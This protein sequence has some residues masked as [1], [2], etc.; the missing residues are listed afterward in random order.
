[1]GAAEPAQ[2]ERSGRGAGPDSPRG[3]DKRP[4][5]ANRRHQRAPLP[6]REHAFPNPGHS[7]YSCGGGGGGGFLLRLGGMDQHRPKLRGNTLR[8]PFRRQRHGEPA[9]APGHGPE[10]GGGGEDAGVLGSA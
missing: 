4:P 3:G 9:Q 10:G 7:R 6:R 1:M 5:P 8:P 2:A